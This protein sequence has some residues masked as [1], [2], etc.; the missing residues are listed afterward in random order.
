MESPRI[1][2]VYYSATGNMHRL[3]EAFAEGAGDAGAEVRLRR[4]A[5]LA[6]DSAIDANPAWRAHLEDTAHIEHA[7]LDDLVWAT[8]FAFGTPTRFGNVS[9]QLKQF[10]DTTG[11]NGHR[12]TQ[13]A[14]ALNPLQAA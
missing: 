6:P 11:G 14:A 7:S 4:V 5:E 2:V 3:A 12:L 13:A 8:G 9:A 1:A 10:L